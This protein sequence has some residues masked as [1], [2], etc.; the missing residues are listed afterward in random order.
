[1]EGTWT[2]RKVITFKYY[3]DIQA[4][5]LNYMNYKTGITIVDLAIKYGERLHD[6]LHSKYIIRNQ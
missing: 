1:M 2:M 5:Y 4:K 3:L 6:K